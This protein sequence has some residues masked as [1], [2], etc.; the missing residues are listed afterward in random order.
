MVLAWGWFTS[1][2][3]R[4][5]AGKAGSA[6]RSVPHLVHCLPVPH[7]KGMNVPSGNGVGVTQNQRCVDA[8]KGKVV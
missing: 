4:C 3:P 5:Q 2:N 7:Q 1:F 6:T 8:A